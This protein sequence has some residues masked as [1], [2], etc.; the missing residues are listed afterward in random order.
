MFARMARAVYIARGA[1][2][3]VRGGRACRV[4]CSP[5]PPPRTARAVS[6]ATVPTTILELYSVL[7]AR[8]V[9]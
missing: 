2:Q 4:T 5:S 8:S 6:A 3:A 7:I 9:I 1:V